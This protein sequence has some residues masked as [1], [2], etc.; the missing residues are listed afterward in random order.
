[1]AEPNE[2]AG[3]RMERYAFIMYGNNFLW[4]TGLAQLECATLSLRVVNSSLML[5][6]EI[7][8]SK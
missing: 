4:G 1:M 2:Q 7:T 5:D 6:V 8:L 3:D